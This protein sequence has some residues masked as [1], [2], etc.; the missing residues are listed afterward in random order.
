MPPMNALLGLKQCLTLVFLHEL[1]L[2]LSKGRKIVVGCSVQPGTVLTFI[3]TNI[4][5][6]VEK[7]TNT[8]LFLDFSVLSSQ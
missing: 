5:T 4:G 8:L 7:E 2:K 1:A 6:G 3:C